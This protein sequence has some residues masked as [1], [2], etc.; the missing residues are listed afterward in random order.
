V[1]GDPNSTAQEM[2]LF[3]RRK[4]TGLCG[5]LEPQVQAENSTDEAGGERDSNNRHS[6]NLR[7]TYDPPRRQARANRGVAGARSQCNN[8]AQRAYIVELSM[9][10]KS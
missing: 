9:T 5:K 7:R 2:R 3:V 1:I 8:R 10:A 6:S 4:V